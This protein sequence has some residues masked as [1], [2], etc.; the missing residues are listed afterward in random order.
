MLTF[1]DFFYIRLSSV[2]LVSAVEIIFRNYSCASYSLLTT[3][4]G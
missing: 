2:V 4:Q 1:G 3:S